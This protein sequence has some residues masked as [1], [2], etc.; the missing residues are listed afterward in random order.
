MVIKIKGNK[1]R[2][3]FN[4]GGLPEGYTEKH[5]LGH[6][7]LSASGLTDQAPNSVEDHGL[8]GFMNVPVTHDN[9]SSNTVI[10]ADNYLS[11]DASEQIIKSIPRIE[12]KKV[13]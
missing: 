5:E 3:D 6:W 4:Q 1:I 12:D 9:G 11:K 10:G 13:Q 8:G 2:I 7:L